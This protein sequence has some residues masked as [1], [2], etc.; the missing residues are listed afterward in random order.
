MKQTTVRCVSW[1]AVSS[2]EQARADKESL[3]EQKRLNLEFIE[4][5]AKYYPGTQG[6]LVAEL[7]V[8]GS[9]S[10][11]RLEEAIKAHDAY[12]RLDEMIRERAFD[13]L[14]CRRRDRIGRETALITT[15]EA[16]CLQA[17]I[18]VAPRS[19]LPHQLDVAATRQNEGQRIV[20]LLESHF[21][22]AEIREFL[23]RGREGRAKRA[24]DGKF[25]SKIPWGWRAAYDE[26]GTRHIH[27][28]TSAA[29]TIRYALLTLYLENGM[30]IRTIVDVLNQEGYRTQHGK[31]WTRAA[32]RNLLN[33]VE[34]YAGWAEFNTESKRGAQ[35]VRAEGKWPPIIT[36]EDAQAIQEERTS[37]AGKS[38]NAE[39]LFSRTATCETCEGSII[40]AGNVDS[41]R[42][43]L[44]RVTYRCI[45]RCRGS[46][47]T[48]ERMKEALLDAI[49][50][51]TKQANRE[52]V[53]RDLPNR[54]TTFQAQIAAAERNLA[55]I[56]EQ[57]DR[58]DH[59]Y[60]VLARL[61]D[62]NYTKISDDLN[63]QE[64][65]IAGQL[66]DLHSALADAEYEQNL[67]GRLDDIASAGRAVL[68]GDTATANAWIRK[69]FRLYVA[70][71]E[72]SRIEYL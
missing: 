60:I 50:W 5:L 35:Y 67:R 24:K 17:G 13:L 51:L 38:Y 26:D 21:A 54:T 52:Q 37:R 33:R 53:L 68:E 49:D 64:K 6:V 14:V 40:V 12:R 32:V 29:A 27:I 22:S 3:P 34:R 61:T 8:I 57:R 42:P 65:A 19:S 20:S 47:I 31:L 62:E 46:H 43:H 45:N 48:D 71:N 15:I 7:E 55:D 36:K 10:I 58:A 11:I 63:A 66:A 59:A 41:R 9:R 16:L 44:V 4:D 25:A 18:I 70:G 56:K 28:D 1:V 69:H 2:D 39:R 23:R 30:P 72:V